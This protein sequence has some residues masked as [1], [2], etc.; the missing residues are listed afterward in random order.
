[1]K[2]FDDI[3]PALQSIRTN[4]SRGYTRW[5]SFSVEAEKVDHIF[6]K[7][8]D[9]FGTQLP[10]WKRQDRKQKKL[11]NAVALSMPILSSKKIIV[12]LM[13]TEEV[14]NMPIETEWQKQKWETKPVEADQFVMVKEPRPSQGYVWTWRLQNRVQDGL[15]AHL[16]ALIKHGDT[17]SV[18]KETNH[19]ARLYPMYG[20]VRRQIAR[21]LRSGEKLWVATK[22][23]PWP[24]Q[25]ADYLPIMRLVNERT[26][27][28]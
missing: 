27:K 24:G 4:F 11:A 21:L 20:G 26:N 17:H 2:K 28:Q 18:Q 9:E 10:S 6:D 8:V 14:M 3:T 5:I 22:K 12:F 16:T 19:W 25:Q 23:T 1:M 15:G 7:W 13:V